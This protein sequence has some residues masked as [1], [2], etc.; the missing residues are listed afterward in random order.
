VVAR[1]GVSRTKI[2]R[3]LRLGHLK[4]FRARG[5]DKRTYIDADALRTLRANPRLREVD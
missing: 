3:L 4:K 2:Y 5:V 1:E